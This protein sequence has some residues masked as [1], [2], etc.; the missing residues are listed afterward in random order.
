MIYVINLIG[1]SDCYFGSCCDCGGDI[2]GCKNAI[3]YYINHHS[4]ILNSK[5]NFYKF[6]SDAI[7]CEKC[8]FKNH[9]IQNNKIACLRKQIRLLNTELE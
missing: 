6:W 5:E 3:R 4:S 8:D 2:E 9:C 1:T 7:D